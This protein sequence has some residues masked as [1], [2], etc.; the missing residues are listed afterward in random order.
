MVHLKNAIRLFIFRPTDF[1]IL[2]YFL[3]YVDY[4]EINPSVVKNNGNISR[5]S[6]KSN[7][8][9]SA[10]AQI[11]LY[12]LQVSLEIFIIVYNT[13]KNWFLEF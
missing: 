5:E 3:F 10:N 11:Y 2:Y 4:I 13:T 6:C 12:D 8:Q 7:K 9:M 1:Y